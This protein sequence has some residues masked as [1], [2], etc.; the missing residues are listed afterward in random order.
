MQGRGWLLPDRLTCGDV[1]EFGAHDSA[2]SEAATSRRWW[3]IVDAYLDGWR[4]TIQGP[5]AAPGDAHA[6]AERLLALDRYQ[7]PKTTDEPSRPAT[8]TR[9]RR[10]AH[11]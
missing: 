10:R 1:L 6:D 5:Y 11:R 8:C 3:G 7:P 9:P 2:R 4:L